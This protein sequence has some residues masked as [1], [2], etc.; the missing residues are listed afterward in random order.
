MKSKHKI[1]QVVKVFEYYADGDII[2]GVY[3]GLIV[4]IDKHCFS[5][6]DGDHNHYI[7]HILPNETAVDRKGV[8][9]AEEFA[10][11]GIA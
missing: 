2:R 9:L 8:Q 4:D 5:R 7:Y 3:Y 11:E 1:G 6:K 10:V